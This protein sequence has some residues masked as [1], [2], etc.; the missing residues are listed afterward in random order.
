MLEQIELDEEFYFN[1]NESN[2]FQDFY[3][4]PPKPLDY[5]LSD[6]MIDGVDEYEVYIQNDL[7]RMN[8]IE[9]DEDDLLCDDCDFISSLERMNTFPIIINS[10][11][12]TFH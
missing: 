4:R 5:T 6:Q 9:C 7:N 3:E 11:F 1:Y 12:H 2:Y 8:S 10:N